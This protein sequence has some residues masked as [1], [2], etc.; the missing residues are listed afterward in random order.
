M[1]ACIPIP[2]SLGEDPIGARLPLGG[3][4]NVECP[5]GGQGSFAGS[6]GRLFLEDEPGSHCNSIFDEAS[7]LNTHYHRALYSRVAASALENGGQQVHLHN[8]CHVLEALS[9][10]WKQTSVR[11]FKWWMGRQTDMQRER[12]MDMGI[13]LPWWQGRVL[14]FLPCP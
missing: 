2:W 1:S 4:R 7:R 10:Q 8:H 5:L 9:S 12:W 6:G 14:N 3:N 13:N 11:W